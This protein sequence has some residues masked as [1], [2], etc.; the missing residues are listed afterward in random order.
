MTFFR[1][2]FNQGFWNNLC[3]NAPNLASCADILVTRYAIFFFPEE[4]RLRDESR[5][6]LRRRLL[7]ISMHKDFNKRHEVS[8]F[9]SPNLPQNR[10]N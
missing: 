10:D 4:E 2:T 1:A 8:P 9:S 7:P 5:E 3:R 6:C